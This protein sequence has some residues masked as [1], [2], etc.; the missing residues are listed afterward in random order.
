[1]RVALLGSAAFLFP[2]HA[3]AQ[4]MLLAPIVVESKRDVATDTAAPTTTIDQREI[5]DRQAST[6]AEL[7]DSVPGVTLMN[8]S[9]PSGSGINIR[10]FG[11]TGTYG[12]DQMVLIQIDGATQ[13]SEE[14]YRL[15]T[16]LYTDPSLY[17]EVTVNRGTVGSFEYGSGVVGG[18]VR[19]RTK[20]A[21]DFTGGV[22]GIAAR[23]TLQYGT[24]GDSVI[25]SS[26]LAWQPTDDLEFLGQYTWQKQNRQEDGD[27][28]D[29]GAEGFILPSYLL[30]GKYTFGAARNQS[31][32]LSYNHT[33]TDESDV[34]YDQ[35][36]LGAGMFGNVDRKI[37]T[38][39]MVMLYEWDPASPLW[40]IEANLSYADQKIDSTY[41]EGSSPFGPTAAALGDADHRYET[42]KLTV[43]N[44][45]AFATGAFDH[46]L[47]AG[48]EVIRK[49]RAEASSA[50]GG[51]DKRFALF[52]VDDITA[53]AWTF[54][55]ALRYETQDLER[56]ASAA[57][58][59][60]TQFDNDAVMGGASVRYDFGN[61]FSTFASGAYT[62]NLPILDDFGN[63]IYM[64]QSQKARTWE[65]GGAFERGDVAMA[66][67]AL[68]VKANLYQTDLWDV[69]SYSGV[70]EV[71][72]KGIELEAAYSMAS[73]FYVDVNAN[74][75]EGDARDAAGAEGYWTNAAAD[76]LRV[77]LGQ[78]LDNGL[79]LSLET[80]ASARFDR[81]NAA[82]PEVPGSVVHNLRASYTPETGPLAGTE[83]RVGVENLFDTDYRPR[84]ATRD[85]PGRNIKFTIAK[86]F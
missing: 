54:S 86:A 58:A 26:I 8:G 7:I 11:A 64:E 5:D 85:A 33:N 74:I 14:L 43:K 70:D 30:K 71:E 66:G 2:I 42:T 69:T 77:T 60:G 68:A 23:Q 59:T 44:T 65:I 31:V 9:T 29:V 53:G 79:D 76:R 51:T 21:S 48:F 75:A 13:G 80:V 39:T 15:G 19:L 38:R 35:F 3:L 78:R 84:L 50:P 1:M 81:V 17:K 24:N 10:G 45:A 25:S 16:Q 57:A 83:L 62:E 56:A 37:N 82:T 46:D 61:G 12:T 4:D 34:P 47:R 55:P 20:D 72:T 40:K 28:E 6:I 52:A 63:Q 67:D 36:G 18:M 22:P 32:T 73:G 49:E 27:G 41:I